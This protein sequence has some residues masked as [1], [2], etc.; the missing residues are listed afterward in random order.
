MEGA[1]MT[2][3]RQ[4]LR[5]TAQMTLAIVVGIILIRWLTRPR[6]DLFDAWQFVIIAVVVAVIL[7]A[8]WPRWKGRR[9]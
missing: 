1:A 7:Y 8:L 2:I 5:E 9:A 4:R 6:L 3:E